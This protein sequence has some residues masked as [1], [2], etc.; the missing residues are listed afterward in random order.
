MY[1]R[2]TNSTKK[3]K[4]PCK[5]LA[6]VCVCSLSRSL[7]FSSCSLFTS[8][9]SWEEEPKCACAGEPQ[10]KAFWIMEFFRQ[11]FNHVT[12]HVGIFTPL[13]PFVSSERKPCVIKS[14]QRSLRAH[15]DISFKSNLLDFF[16]PLPQLVQQKL[17]WYN[18]RHFKLQ[19][20]LFKMLIYPCQKNYFKQNTFGQSHRP[21][22]TWRHGH[23]TFHWSCLARCGR[24]QKKSTNQSGEKFSCGS[25]VSTPTH[26]HQEAAMG[27]L[28]IKEHAEEIKWLRI[29]PERLTCSSIFARTFLYRE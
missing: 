11:R 28:N 29:K 8:L 16:F 2:N 20:N 7:S 23:S 1:K 18:Q 9:Y 14:S 3:K 12:A 25:H 13:Q 5:V 19:K 26:P 4:N 6:G 24:D 17:H 22:N 15:S 27:S 21:S 10:R